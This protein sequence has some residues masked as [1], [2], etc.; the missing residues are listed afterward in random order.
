M[1]IEIWDTHDKLKYCQ[2]NHRLPK[3]IYLISLFLCNLAGCKT[4]SLFTK[5]PQSS[6]F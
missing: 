1:D 5:S 3:E 6:G 2:L 4:L